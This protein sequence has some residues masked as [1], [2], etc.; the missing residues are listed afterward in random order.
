MIPRWKINPMIKDGE[1]LFSGLSLTDTDKRRCVL[2]SVSAS[3]HTLSLLSALTLSCRPGRYK[4]GR[5]AET[6]HWRV[7]RSRQQNRRTKGQQHGKKS[8]F[9]SWYPDTLIFNLLPSETNVCLCLQR[10]SNV[11]FELLLLGVCGWSL[12]LSSATQGRF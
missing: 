2:C 5:G 1:L 3:P 11:I 12:G 6:E 10:V 7:G 4:E 8:W 9:P